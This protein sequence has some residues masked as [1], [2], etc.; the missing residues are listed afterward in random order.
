MEEAPVVDIQQVKERLDEFGYCIVED[1]M[2]V[3]EAERIAAHYFLLH[4]Q[5]FPQDQTY[6]SLQGLL[7]HDQMC[8]PWV[9]Q[10]QILQL[11][12]HY[13]GSRMRFAEAASKCVKPGAAPGGVHA[14]SLG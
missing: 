1:V 12:R 10:P 13:L 14:D 5:H 6:Q 8:W 4:E 9:T 3:E 2:P 11:A 7:N